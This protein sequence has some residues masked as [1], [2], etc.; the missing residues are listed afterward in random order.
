MYSIS[1]AITFWLK[2]TLG[3]SSLMNIVANIDNTLCFWDRVL[4]AMLETSCLTN[5]QLYS[6]T[7]YGSGPD[8]ANQGIAL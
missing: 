8:M 7:V 3:V 1:N 5:L 6:A 2:Y 4:C